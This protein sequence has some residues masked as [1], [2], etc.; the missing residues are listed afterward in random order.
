MWKEQNIAFTFLAILFL[1]LSK[2]TKGVAR[3]SSG[4]S[5]HFKGHPGFDSQ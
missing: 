3:L 5:D 4:K 1:K 2:L